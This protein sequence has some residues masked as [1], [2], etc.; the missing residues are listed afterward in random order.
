MDRDT[1]SNNDFLFANKS[2]GFRRNSP[3]RLTQGIVNPF[4]LKFKLIEN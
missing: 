4:H 2:P 3:R 1:E